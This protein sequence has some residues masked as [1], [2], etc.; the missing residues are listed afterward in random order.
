MTIKIEPVIRCDECGKIIEN[1]KDGFI[2]IGGIFVA[3]VNKDGQPMRGLIGPLFF[4]KG[5]RADQV[6]P[7]EE[8]INKKV[9]CTECLL[10]ILGIKMRR[11]SVER[12]EYLT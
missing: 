12:E 8:N 5:K 3:E 9:F 1:A 10:G 11:P 2:I 7:S 6:I 4:E